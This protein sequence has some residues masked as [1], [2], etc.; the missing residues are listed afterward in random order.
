[1]DWL[2]WGM[3]MLLKETAGQLW[4]SSEKVTKEDFDSLIFIFQLVNHCERLLRWVCSCWVAMTWSEEADN[5]AVSSAYARTMVFSEV[6]RSDVWMYKNGAMSLLWG[7][8]AKIGYWF[9]CSRLKQTLNERYSRWNVCIKELEKYFL[10]YIFFYIFHSW[11][12]NGIREFDN[13]LIDIE[14]WF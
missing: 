13:C 11:F 8:P 9:E 1:M 2:Q 6:S 12:L 14:R 7:S 3:M 4:G 5:K 10:I